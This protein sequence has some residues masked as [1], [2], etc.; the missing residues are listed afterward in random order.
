M[1][2]LVFFVLLFLVFAKF[3][4]MSLPSLDFL[5]PVD[6]IELYNCFGCL[7]FAVIGLQVMNLFLSAKLPLQTHLSQPLWLS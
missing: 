4:T 5:L 6:F 1:L 2:T 7:D 3:Y